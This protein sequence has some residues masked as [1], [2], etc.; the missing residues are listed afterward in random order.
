MSDL[1]RFVSPAAADSRYGDL[2]PGNYDPIGQ[3]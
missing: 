3:K 2:N 1:R